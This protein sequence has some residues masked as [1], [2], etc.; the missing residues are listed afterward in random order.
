MMDKIAYSS[1]LRE[2]NP[3]LKTVFAVG[4]LLLCIF[5]R[6][7]LFS[8]F[9]LIGMGLLLKTYVKTSL[10]MWIH[11]IVVPIL[12]VILS[13][14]TILINISKEPLSGFAVPIGAIYLTA[15][16]EGIKTSCNLAMTAFASISCLYFLS[17]TTPVI[18]L[19][20]VLKVIRCP[21]LIIE[22]ILLIYR[23]I[24]ILANTASS[25]HTA[26]KCRLSET[27]YRTLLSAW[28]QMLAI[29]FVLALKRSRAVYDA[30][31]ARCYDGRINVLLEMPQVSIKEKW[32]LGGYFGFMI[33]LAIIIGL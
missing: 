12:F 24:F 28:S 5:T 25:I 31:E 16:K 11:L 22:L 15:S 7:L 26:Q 18:D 3:C 1:K 30:M 13:T 23:F 9:I 8:S 17:L 2:K 19:L 32:M 10:H 33:L 20:T 29:L 14:I 4:T 21:S 6:N 27:N